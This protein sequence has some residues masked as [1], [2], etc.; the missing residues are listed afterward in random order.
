MKNHFAADNYELRVTGFRLLH[1]VSQSYSQSNTEN[2]TANCQHQ[3]HKRVFDYENWFEKGV[4]YFERCFG[5]IGN[6]DDFLHQTFRQ[7]TRLSA[8]RCRA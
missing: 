5:I 7:K 8:S 6:L 1:R 2:F 3:I 4:G